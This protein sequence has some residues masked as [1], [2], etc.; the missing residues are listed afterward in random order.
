LKSPQRASVRLLIRALGLPPAQAEELELAV[1]PRAEPNANG[2]ARHNL[3][4]QLTSFVGRE[5]DVFEASERLARTRL[6]TL[7]GIGGGGKTRLALEIARGALPKYADGVWLVE[8]A[9]LGDPLLVPRR[10]A[11]VVGVNEN[12]DQP[13]TTALIAVLASRHMLLVLDNCEHLLLACSVLVD[14]LL[15]SCPTLRILAT[16]REAFGIQ[17][18]VAWQVSSLAVPDRGGAQTVREAKQSPAVQ[19]FVER[20]IAAQPRFTLTEHNRAAVVQICQRLDG[21]PLALELAAAR[22]L[23]LTP[24]QVVERLDKSFRLLAGGS[25]IALPRQQTLHAALDWS[26]D[27]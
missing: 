24:T 25:R 15:R 10:V 4:V 6:L 3:P 23:A 27:L 20:A 16:S 5:S 8:L 26:Y 13:V 11:G 14:A 21:I 2:M 18:E 22:V 7:T 19:L 12:P 17:G 9:P 1:R